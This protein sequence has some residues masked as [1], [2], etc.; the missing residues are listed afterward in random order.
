M[1]LGWIR[2]P[3]ISLLS[4]RSLHTCIWFRHDYI[5]VKCLV[6]L[7]IIVIISLNFIVWRNIF[8]V[9]I[10]TDMLFHIFPKDV[11][12]CSVDGTRRCKNKRYDTEN[13]RSMQI[14]L[15]P[16]LLFLKEMH[17]LWSTQ[18]DIFLSFNLTVTH[19][20]SSNVVLMVEVC[21]LDPHKYIQYIGYETLRHPQTLQ[22]LFYFNSIAHGICKQFCCMT[23]PLQEK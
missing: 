9:G 7:W 20:Y 10:I 17:S 13:F 18:V 21:Y 5:N 16:D 23:A 14:T 22:Y 19:T 4:P 8:V 12:D 1:C 15:R 6:H 2:C 3:G 11:I